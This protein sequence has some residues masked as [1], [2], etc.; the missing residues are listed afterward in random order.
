MSGG[1][2]QETTTSTEPW[3]GVAPSLRNLYQSAGALLGEPTTLPSMTPG[4]RRQSLETLTNA[5]DAY[6]DF[7]N[8]FNERGAPGASIRA[9]TNLGVVPFTDEELAAQGMAKDLAGSPLPASLQTASSSIIGMMGGQPQDTAAY[10][11]TMKTVSGDYLTPDSN[12]YLRATY[13]AASQPL[14]EQFQA[15]ILPA[16]T[17]QFGAG[18]RFGSGS[19]EYYVNQAGRQLEDSLADMA[20]QL[21]GGAY[22]QE[23]GLQEAATGR[24]AQIDEDVAHRGLQAAALA[25]SVAGLQRDIGKE[26]IGLLGDVGAAQR[27][28]A[29]QIL[30]QVEGSAQDPWQQLANYSQL[31]Q[32]GLNFQTQSTPYYTNQLAG[33]LGGGLSGA[34]MGYMLGG[35]VGAGIGGLGGLVLGGLL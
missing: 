4:E 7:V 27:A 11:P 35:P 30:G 21:Y 23:R 28:M 16:I 17:G 29:Q 26:N 12:P 8:Y 18:G 3:S 6:Q 15:N 22:Q 25:P 31:L 19:H 32:G 34:G 14:I 13:E 24:L 5:P 1:G 9:G 2:S 20:S 10:D 33:A